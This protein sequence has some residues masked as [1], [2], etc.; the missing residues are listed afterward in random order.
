MKLTVLLVAAITASACTTMPDKKQTSVS[1]S[2]LYLPNSFGSD[3]ANIRKDKMTRIYIALKQ[4]NQQH[5][6][7]EVKQ[8][9]KSHD[10][11]LIID[12]TVYHIGASI[13]DLGKKWFAFCKM[14]INA[15]EIISRI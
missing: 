6:K 9:D 2:T 14:N 3:T 10:R 12:D 7:I 13:K 1:E 11:F 8:F 15:E 5:E 4:H